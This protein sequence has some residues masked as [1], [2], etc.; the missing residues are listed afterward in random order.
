LIVLA[1]WNTFKQPVIVTRC[2]NNYGP[3]QDLEKLIP[4]IISKA[5]MDHVV[6]IYGS[7]L[8]VRDWLFVEDHVS[9]LITI[10]L[11][12][13]IGQIFNISGNNE[14]SNLD[15]ATFI[16]EVMKKP[17]SLI[18]HVEDRKGHDLRYSLD[19]SKLEKQYAWK[20]KVDFKSGIKVTIDW[21]L[22]KLVSKKVGY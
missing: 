13:E 12:G 20:P 9:A 17:L 11:Q 8:N 5:T 18:Q 1:N 22:S 7:G 3:Y 14:L 4:T 19:S 15:V 6:P 10:L 16:L 21:Y 2:T